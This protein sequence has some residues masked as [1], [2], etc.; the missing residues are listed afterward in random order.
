MKRILF[1]T[2]MLIFGMASLAGATSFQEI[3]AN[4]A[5]YALMAGD[6][7]QLSVYFDRDSV[8]FIGAKDGVTVLG[9][10]VILKNQ[11]IAVLD[12]VFLYEDANPDNFALELVGSKIFNLAGEQ[13]K[14]E[15]GEEVRQMVPVGSI[16][17]DIGKRAQTI[18]LAKK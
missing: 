3:K 18:Y 15:P 5:R 13:I 16:A 7:S 6:D 2:M 11:E 17:Y 4:P 14:E 8:K 12:E 10:Q 1:L 9:V